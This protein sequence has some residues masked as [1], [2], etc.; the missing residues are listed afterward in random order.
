MAVHLGAPNLLNDKDGIATERY[1]A[2][3]DEIWEL[4]PATGEIAYGETDVSFW[5]SLPQE[6]DTSCSEGNPEGTPF[7]KPF[8]VIMYAH[9]YGG[10][11]NEISL[12]M[13]RHNAMGYAMCSLDSYGHGLNRWR[14]DPVAGA[15]IRLAVL[16]LIAMALQNSAG[17]SPMGETEI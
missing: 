17:C 12:H 4:S 14:E 8:P 9:G 3:N 16:S 13:G 1:P 7:C 6:L 5:C 15:A 11:R 2:D 10:S